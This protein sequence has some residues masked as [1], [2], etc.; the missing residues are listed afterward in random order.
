MALGQGVGKVR[1]PEDTYTE[2]LLSSGSKNCHLLIEIIFKHQN[3]AGK[4]QDYCYDIQASDHNTDGQ[5]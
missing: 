5:S 2:I 4:S 3:M 1:V